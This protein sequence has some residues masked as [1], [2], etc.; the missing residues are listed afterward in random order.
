MF[1]LSFEPITTQ[2][3][4][5]KIITARL[6]REREKFADYDDI[7]A[8]ATAGAEAIAERDELKT[9]L[10]SARREH[11]AVTTG[12]PVDLIVGD[13]AEAMQAHADGIR[14]V[15]DAAAA[16]QASAEAAAQTSAP[17]PSG[18]FVEGVGDSGTP[19]H[20]PLAELFG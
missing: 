20:N 15:I 2:E 6:S 5:D 12:V 4:L 9:E 11:I 1:E 7:K 19:P 3:D 10:L 14:A 17:A 13:T 18:P 16:T 8:A